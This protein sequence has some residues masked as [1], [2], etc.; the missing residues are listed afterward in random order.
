MPAVE[1]EDLVAETCVVGSCFPSSTGV[2]VLPPASDP[3][4]DPDLNPPQPS[5]L[6]QIR[7]HNQKWVILL[8]RPQPQRREIH[9]R[10]PPRIHAPAHPRDINP[11]MITRP[12]DLRVTVAFLAPHLTTRNT[13]TNRSKVQTPIP[14]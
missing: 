1:V 7:R 6:Q 4:P 8:G 13:L 12:F 5:L 2:G 10:I 14:K 9:K 11:H 3:D